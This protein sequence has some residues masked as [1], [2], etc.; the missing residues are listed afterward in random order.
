MNVSV[1]INTDEVTKGL[2]GIRSDVPWVIQNTINDLLKNAQQEQFTTMRRNFIIRNESFMKYSVRIGFASRQTLSGKLFIA[3]I[4]GKNT[5]NIWERFEGGDRK[6]PTRSKNISVP[7]TSAWANKGR[8]LSPKNKPRALLRSFVIKSGGREFIFNRIGKKS[9]V[10]ST[11]RD[12]NVKMM[13]TLA[14]NVRIPDKLN[15]YS[16]VIPSI[17]QN[18]ESTINRLL[19]V[20]LSKRGF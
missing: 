17:E 4:G 16:T 14:P 20:S 10:D 19:Q 3:D 5:S 6:S 7:S 2:A 8:K 15:F 9:K 12:A 11:G 1:K 13:Y 18:Y